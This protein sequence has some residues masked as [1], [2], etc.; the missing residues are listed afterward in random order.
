MQQCSFFDYRV[1]PTIAQKFCSLAFSPKH[2]Y[3]YVVHLSWERGPNVAVLSYEY[4]VRRV[5]KNNIEIQP[6]FHNTCMYI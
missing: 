1:C 5:E 6:E 2:K 4:C 3:M